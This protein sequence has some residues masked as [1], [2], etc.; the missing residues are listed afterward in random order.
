MKKNKIFISFLTALAIAG[1]SIVPA[2]ATLESDVSSIL[3]YVRLTN[4]D[5]GSIESYV[6]LYLP[7]LTQIKNGT[8]NIY[9]RLYSTNQYLSDI[10]SQINLFDPYIRNISNREDSNYLNLATI[11]ANSNT[12]NTNVQQLTDV[13][14]N[15]TDSAIRQDYESR[16]AEVNDDFLSSSGDASVSLGDIGSSKQ[17]VTALKDSLSGGASAS[18]LWSVLTSNSEG[19]GWFSQATLNDLDQTGSGNRRSAPEYEYLND[20]YFQVMNS[21]GGEYND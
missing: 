6:N 9:T 15:A 4:S 1:T 11:R 14:A 3:N 16:V 18:S 19:W 12:I 10:K 7:S 8:D 20:Y 5:V 17:S 13:L 21:L 2:F